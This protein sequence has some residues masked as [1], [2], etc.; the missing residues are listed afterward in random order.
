MDKTNASTQA[1]VND[2]QSSQNISDTMANMN[3]NDAEQAGHGE[4]GGSSSG[5]INSSSQSDNS[6]FVGL[7]EGQA[8][9]QYFGAQ[10]N[11][12]SKLRGMGIVSSPSRLAPIKN[13]A[14]IEFNLEEAN[15]VANGIIMSINIMAGQLF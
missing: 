12:T 6:S 3:L 2:Q 4:F 8:N 13:K 15:K 1:A 14:T 5:G 9:D 10:P 11:P 7:S